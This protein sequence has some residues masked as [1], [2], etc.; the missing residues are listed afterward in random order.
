MKVMEPPIETL[1]GSTRRIRV[2]EQHFTTVKSPRGDAMY[3]ETQPGR[4][5][6]VA[7]YTSNCLD[8]KTPDFVPLV[9]DL[10]AI[11]GGSAKEYLND[12][13]NSFFP[14]L[15]DEITQGELHRY[16][17]HVNQSFIG[18]SATGNILLHTLEFSFDITLIFVKF[19]TSGL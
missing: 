13:A 11:L 8:M 18:Y 3:V 1:F 12:Y 6:S 14:A 7:E 5:V 9:D 17:I 19:E 10:P 16:M 4:V 15:E 2:P